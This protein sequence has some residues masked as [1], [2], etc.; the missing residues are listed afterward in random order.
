LHHQLAIISPPLISLRH[1]CPI[2]SYALSAIAAPIVESLVW[3]AG[4]LVPVLARDNF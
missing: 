1:D 3:I 2:G 4:W